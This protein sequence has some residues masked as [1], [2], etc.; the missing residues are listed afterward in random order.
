MRKVLVTTTIIC[1]IICIVFG[2]FD[3]I[4]KNE[5]FLFIS[6]TFIPITYALCMA[7]ILYILFTDEI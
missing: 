7:N 3:C 6:G 4:T 1:F 5:I 2:I